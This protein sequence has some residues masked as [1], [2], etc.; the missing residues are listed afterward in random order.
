M[1]R[2]RQRAK[3]TIATV[4][5]AYDLKASR[6][7][8]FSALIEANLPLL[9]HALGVGGL[10]AVKP[11]VAGPA[12]IESMHVARGPEDLILRHGA[13]MQQLPTERTH[14]QTVTGPFVASEKTAG[15]PEMFRTWRSF[16][17]GAEDALGFMTVD[18]DGR[19]IHVLAPTPHLVRLTPQERSEW[20]MISAHV[21]SGLRLRHAIERAASAEPS[22]LPFDAEAI[23]DP[24]SFRIAEAA[25][26]ARVPEALEWLRQAAIRVDRARVTGRKDGET[27]AALA[28]WWALI[29]GRWSVVDWFDSDGRRYVLALP[30]PPDVPNP[31]GLTK[32][33][34]QVVAFAALGDS[35]KLIAYRLGL[36]RSRVTQLLNSSM[37]KLGV[38]TQAELVAKL[39]ALV[40]TE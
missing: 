20:E 30:N 8:W 27:H 28:E 7:E 25:G 37:R 11:R 38:K 5:A 16:F 2:K 13:A 9:D 40:D 18:A 1:P 19:G 15:H 26:D 35:H 14:E 6:K 23:I 21:A 12:I 39:R 17:D 24:S 4:E 10:V 29:R 36:S 31:R 3:A 22:A 34:Q 33:E 32:R